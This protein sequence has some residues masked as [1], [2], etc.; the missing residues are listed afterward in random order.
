MSRNKLIVGLSALAV[1]AGPPPPKAPS[2]R[3]TWR[4]RRRPTWCPIWPPCIRTR[5]RISLMRRSWPR[6]SMLALAY[7]RADYTDQD[8]MKHWT[9]A[10][11]LGRGGSITS[12]AVGAESRP[13][14]SDYVICTMPSAIRAWPA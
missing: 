10:T 13:E 14:C 1:T 6:S 5:A 7:T 9:P 8:A 11:A 4:T 2:S 12:C 3:V